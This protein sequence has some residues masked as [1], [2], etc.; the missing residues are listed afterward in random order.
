M[1]HRGHG[2]AGVSEPGT[3]LRRRPRAS[4]ARGLIELEVG[5][6]F[7]VSGVEV[8]GLVEAECVLGV[9]DEVMLWRSTCGCDVWRRGGQVE[10]SE[11]GADGSGVG[12]EGEDAHGGSASRAA[13]REDLIDAREESSPTGASGEVQI[14]IGGTGLIAGRGGGRGRRIGVI[15]VG[16]CHGDDARAQAGIGREDAVV[17][18]AVDARGWDEAGECGEEFERGQHEQFAAVGRGP[19]RPVEDPSHGTRVAAGLVGPVA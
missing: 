16:V 3:R 6:G 2:G 17:A 15:G 13:E 8:R 19:R 5:Y 10:V 12:E 9:E 4:R 7:G 1:A 18:M 14:G 11:D